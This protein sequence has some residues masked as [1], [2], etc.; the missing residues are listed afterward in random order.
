MT[1]FYLHWGNTRVENE[2]NKLFFKSI[3]DAT[4]WHN[5]LIVKYA[6][7]RDKWEEKYDWDKIKFKKCNLWKELNFELANEN[8]ETFITQIKNNDL[9]YF[10]WGD[11]L[12]LLNKM[13]QI[14]NLIELFDWKVVA[15]SS[16]W[17]LIFANY[18]YSNDKEQIFNWLWMLDINLI[19]HYDDILVIV[20]NRIDSFENGMKTVT[21]KNY[22]YV[23]YEQQ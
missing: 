8:N 12:R 20:K 14:E 1:K 13:K 7:D 17:A 3:I 19:C 5:I 22:E 4:K 15:W 18:F 11:T 10:R 2:Q 21:I 16:A 6:T 9:I 23:V